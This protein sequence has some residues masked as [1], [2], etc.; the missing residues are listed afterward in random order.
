LIEMIDG[1]PAAQSPW[2]KGLIAGGARVD[3]RGLVVR[4]VQPTAPQP[5]APDVPESSDTEEDDDA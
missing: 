3:Y 1:L 4:G 2:G 5:E